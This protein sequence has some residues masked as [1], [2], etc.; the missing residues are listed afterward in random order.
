MR[1]LLPGVGSAGDVH[2]VVGVGRELRARGHDVTVLTDPHF[3]PVVEAAGLA[4]A[5]CGPPDLYARLVRNPELW[6]A[7]RGF[8]TLA[9]EALVPLTEPTFDYIRATKPDLVAASSLCFGARVAQEALGVPLVS[10]YVQ[11]MMIRSAEA[12]PSQA[13]FDV[14]SWMPRWAMELVYGV[15]DGVL[16]DRHLAGVKALRARLGLPAVRG[17]I[18]AWSQS[19][20]GVIGMFPPDLVRVPTDW[21]ARLAMT[22]FVESDPG[23]L[24]A[25]ELRSF[26][27][28]PAPVVVTFGSAMQHA[29]ALYGAFATALRARGQRVILLA[30]D[31]S[32]L[33]GLA[34]PDVLELAWA[35]LGP[36]LRR[37]RALVHHGGI[38]TCG[39]ALAAGVPQLIV[40][41]AHDQFD[42]LRHVRRLG[43][44]LGVD[45]DR[46]STFEAAI[47]ALLA[48]EISVRAASVSPRFVA[49]GATL[50]ADLLEAVGRGVPLPTR[51]SPPAPR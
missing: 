16:I 39:R 43:V 1:I 6:N 22:G 19:P 9:R 3:R 34:D 15:V 21:P 41:H 51:A 14:P 36:L 4:F 44:G 33:P 20:L 50:T 49:D 48:P 23:D 13:F 25:L 10:L 40:P 8:S 45:R 18:G 37:S 42:N 24:D 26:L 46:P 31:T 35:P 7:R 11:P 38:G 5:T 12:P 29:H 2:P 30:A 27:S 17:Y 47:D 28:G 32:Q